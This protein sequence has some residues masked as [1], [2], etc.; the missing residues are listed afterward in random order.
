[1]T[2]VE[3]KLQEFER[4]PTAVEPA[5]QARKQALL[6]AWIDINRFEGIYP[7]ELDKRLFR[8]LAAGKV[9]Q[10]EYRELSLLAARSDAA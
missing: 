7:T 6:D 8:V 9:S 3:Q 1:M 10:Q 2:A 5:E 4:R